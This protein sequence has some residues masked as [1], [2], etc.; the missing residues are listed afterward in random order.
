MARHYLGMK[1]SFMAVALATLSV[2]ALASASPTLRLA[3]EA[4]DDCPS[5]SAFSAALAT[6]SANFAPDQAT[7][8]GPAMVVSIRRQGEEFAGAFQLQNDHSTT[9]RREVR[10]A[11]CREV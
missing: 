10:G 7:G 9:N 8:S 1:I 6:R 2:S 3:Y 11:D 4:P 5:R